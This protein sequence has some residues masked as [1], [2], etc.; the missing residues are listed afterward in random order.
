MKNNTQ[1]MPI[2]FHLMYKGGSMETDACLLFRHMS[3]RTAVDET[4]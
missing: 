4:E 1:E 3:D 2:I